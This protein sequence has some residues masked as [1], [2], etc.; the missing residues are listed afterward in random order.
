MAD[1]ADEHQLP[2]G[3]YWIRNTKGK[4]LATM[5]RDLRRKNGGFWV[6]GRGNV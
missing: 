3:E 1:F 2:D 5:F 6:E 4:N